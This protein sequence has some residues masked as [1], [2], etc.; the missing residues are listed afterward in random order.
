MPSKILS[1]T[2]NSRAI[3]EEISMQWFRSS[4]IKKKKMVIK[5]YYK[6]N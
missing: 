6:T 4:K 5:E 2:L 1:E 3:N